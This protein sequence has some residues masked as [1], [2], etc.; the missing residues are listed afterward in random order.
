MPPEQ[1]AGRQADVGPASDVY[2]LGAILYYA[3]T[4]KAPFTGGT[5]LEVMRKVVEVEPTAPSKINARTPTDLETIC[6]KCLEKNPQRRYFSAR[7]L[8]EELS[9]FL[10]EQPILAKPAGAVRKAWSWTQRNPWSVTGLAAIVILGLSGLSFGLWEHARILNERYGKIPAPRSY[11]WS[12]AEAATLMVLWFG[13]VF[14]AVGCA[15]YIRDRRRRQ[16]PVSNAYLLFHSFIG[17]GVMVAG[18]AVGAA[19]ISTFVWMLNT[20]ESRGNLEMIASVIM[21]LLIVWGGLHLVTQAFQ[22]HRV[23]STGAEQA[24]ARLFSEEFE[25]NLKPFVGTSILT[26]AALWISTFLWIP[27]KHPWFPGFD[28]AEQRAISALASSALA[29]LPVMMYACLLST[30]QA[31]AF[32]GISVCA[33]CAWGLSQSMA[34][35]LGV[36]AVMIYVGLLGGFVI[37]L[38][39][40]IRRR[41]EPAAS[42]ISSFADALAWNRPRFLLGVFLSMIGSILLVKIVAVVAA[43]FNLHIT[44]NLGPAVGIAFLTLASYPLRVWKAQA[45]TAAFFLGMMGLQFCVCFP[46]FASAMRGTPVF[47]ETCL[48][49]LIG[50]A[51]G[52]GL[53]R[54]GSIRFKADALADCSLTR[55]PL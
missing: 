21:S 42:A 39:S 55:A 40:G 24:P 29:Q 47:I 19:N 38:S 15:I 31:R 37:L 5:P 18:I 4:G 30:G 35:F 14:T 49:L 54:A 12:N 41:T 28:A 52:Q 33:L 43:N 32:F 51:A 8:A 10:N 7:E 17:L 23:N 11:G 27:E 45:P 48:Y 20:W 22:R 34:Y 1:A 36:F 26:H 16:A 9:R 3:L 50:L 13:F 46:L 2:S 44:G 6:L 53:V 25:I